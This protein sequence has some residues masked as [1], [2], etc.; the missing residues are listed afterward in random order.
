MPRATTAGVDGDWRPAPSTTPAPPIAPDARRPRCS[1]RNRSD[2][3]SSS[4]SLSSPSLAPAAYDDAL[5]GEG[6]GQG[7]L[8]VVELRGPVPD[9]AGIDK[10]DPPP[11]AARSGRT[12]LVVEQQLTNSIPSKTCPSESRSHCDRPHGSLPTSAASAALEQQWQDLA[13]PEAR[14]SRDRPPTVGRRGRTR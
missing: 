8:F 5:L 10:D 7:H 9:P 6:T 12:P 13:T 2:G 14:W 11:G 4:A 3:S 1:R